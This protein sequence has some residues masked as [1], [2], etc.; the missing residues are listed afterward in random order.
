[1][2]QQIQHQQV[3][4]IRVELIDVLN[5]RERG[6]PVFRQMT[7]N[8]DAIGLKRPIT[9]S[10]RV[11]G[12]G[13]VR[14]AVI[15]GQGRLEIFRALG[16]KEIPAFVTDVQDDDC[17]VMSLV[18]NV[19]RRRHSSAEMVCEI[20]SLQ[21]R[22]LTALQISERIGVSK[23]WVLIVLSLLAKGEI[24]LIQ[25]VESGAIPLTLAISISRS[26]EAEVQRLLTQAYESGTLRGH[27][28]G[29]VRRLLDKRARR[30]APAKGG[31]LR[32]SARS[33][34]PEQ[35]S[36]MYEEEV[37]K[38]RVLAKEAA[39]TH[40]ALLFV[41]QALRELVDNLGFIQLLRAA[42][43]QSMPRVLAIERFE[44]TEQ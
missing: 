37:N 44:E 2:P 42:G 9:V 1:M 4:M 19:A 27:K 32:T 7:A 17:M 36:A 33:M 23:D 20:E 11:Q 39:Y 41:V 43:L 38:Q 30:N 22:G 28:L 25:G 16:Q 15:C 29:V 34:T 6:R 12:D 18:E 24:K 21:S 26:G 35:L 5:P 3:E 14:Y 40:E 8:V 31:T 13:S 10:R